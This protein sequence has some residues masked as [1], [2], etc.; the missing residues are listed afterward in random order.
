MLAL[1]GVFGLRRC[2]D[3]EG[4]DC[5]FDDQDLPV[6]K[7]QVGAYSAALL[8]YTTVLGDLRYFGARRFSSGSVERP[9]NPI[10]C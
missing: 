9:T 2:G 10:T 4:V 8:S 3:R 5:S 6:V 7:E 1:T